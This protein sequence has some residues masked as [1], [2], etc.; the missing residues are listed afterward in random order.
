[1]LCRCIFGVEGAG[2]LGGDEAGVQAFDD[3]AAVALLV[4]AVE[5]EAADAQERR[6]T[7]PPRGAR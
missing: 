1:V 7:L 6:V 4:F 2:V 3:V 5:E